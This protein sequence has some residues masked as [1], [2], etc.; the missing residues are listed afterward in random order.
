[1]CL[2]QLKLWA[3]IPWLGAGRWFSPGTPV[4]STNK[5]DSH[6]IT[7]ILLKVALNTLPMPTYYWNICTKHWE[8][9]AKWTC[10]RDIEFSSVSLNFRLEFGTVWT[11]WFFFVF[12]LYPL[13]TCLSVLRRYT[14]SDY[15]FGILD[16]RIL[17]T[18]LVS[19]NSSY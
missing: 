4:S 17:I 11:V 8:W 3:P 7:K 15:P 19:S 14:D 1:M 13:F 2:S 10:V 5:T 12:Q 18:P 16:I 9:A 6:D